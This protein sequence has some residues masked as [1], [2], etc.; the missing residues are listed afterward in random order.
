MEKVIALRFDNLKEISV[1]KSLIEIGL[2][3]L[4]VSP[5]DAVIG[6]QI[7]EQLNNCGKLIQKQNG[8]NK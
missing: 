8:Q 7:I 4:E 1:V 5:G 3:D 6:R 2:A